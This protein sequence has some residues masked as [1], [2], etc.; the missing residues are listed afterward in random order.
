V[1]DLVVDLDGLDAFAGQLTRI[2]DGMDATRRLIDAA[3]SE[4]G[5]VDVAAA[6]DRFEDRWHDGREK[7]DANGKT[8]ATM[9]TESTKAYRE[10]DAE[11]TTSLHDSIH[12][13]GAFTPSHLT[14][15]SSTPSSS[16]SGPR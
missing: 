11:L 3:R 10:A 1:A 4:L 14:P 15:S 16:T 13:G 5:S 2:T 7:I 6:L 9:V 8:L 12:S